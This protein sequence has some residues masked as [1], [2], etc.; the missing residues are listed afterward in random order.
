MQEGESGFDF[1]KGKVGK[2]NFTMKD[3][4]PLWVIYFDVIVWIILLS[5]GL[6]FVFQYG[7]N[8]TVVNVYDFGG[9]DIGGGEV[10][11][12]NIT[13]FMEQNSLEL[14]NITNRSINGGKKIY[15]TRWT[16][17]G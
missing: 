7:Y 11:N 9:K 12:L 1:M 8:Y 13:A 3:N 2:E 15:N 6:F 10:R 17:N 14:I 16:G 4:R 5:F